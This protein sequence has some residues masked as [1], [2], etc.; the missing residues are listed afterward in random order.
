VREA[1]ESPLLETVASEQLMMTQQH[2]KRL[3]SA[4]VIFEL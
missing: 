1:E 2:V 4:V 3:A